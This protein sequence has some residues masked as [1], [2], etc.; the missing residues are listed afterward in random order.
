MGG[1]AGGAG[2][3]SADIDAKLA[4]YAACGADEAFP[5]FTGGLVTGRY[6]RD[7]FSPED[8]RARH[9][10]L[11]ARLSAVLGLCRDDLG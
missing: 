3:L 11:V 10:D 7:A 2:H 5:D 8:A 1:G 4:Y 9:G 6:S